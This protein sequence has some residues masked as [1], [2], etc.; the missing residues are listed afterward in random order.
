MGLVVC[1][2]GY[3]LSVV[4]S[5]EC[6]CVHCVIRRRC[7]DGGGVTV[8][9]TAAVVGT[10]AVVGGGTGCARRRSREARMVHGRPDS[11]PST[12]TGLTFRTDRPRAED[13]SRS[14]R[15][16]LS[17]SGSFIQPVL[18]LAI[19]WEHLLR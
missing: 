12:E 19:S 13:P 17:G 11:S 18:L 2:L 4:S 3:G 9:G 10:E 1:V 16:E 15:S 8:V 7:I 14:R 6:V 5:C